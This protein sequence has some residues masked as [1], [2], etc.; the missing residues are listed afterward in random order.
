[1]VAQEFR[2]I[3]HPDSI[4]TFQILVWTEKFGIS[5]C[6]FMIYLLCYRFGR[7]FFLLSQKVLTMDPSE[8]A[9][10]PLLRFGIS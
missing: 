8:I 3:S 5:L 2:Y 10:W 7:G 9:D 6:Y 4:S 1:M